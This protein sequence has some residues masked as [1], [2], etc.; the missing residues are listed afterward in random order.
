M[1]VWPDRDHMVSSCDE[2]AWLAVEGSILSVRRWHRERFAAQHLLPYGG[3]TRQNVVRSSEARRPNPG[4]AIRTS[5]HAY[6]RP[7][8]RE[9][10]GEI[11]DG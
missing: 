5:Q 4:T 6:P 11:V 8:S 2:R 3:D 9:D 7:T 1:R 10:S